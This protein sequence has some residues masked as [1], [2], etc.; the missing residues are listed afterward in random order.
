MMSTKNVKSG[1]MV[2]DGQLFLKKLDINVSEISKTNYCRFSKM[3]VH[4][5]LCIRKTSIAETVKIYKVFRNI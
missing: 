2:F 1:K 5:F 3:N 4:G